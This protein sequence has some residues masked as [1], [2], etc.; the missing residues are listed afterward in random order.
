MNSRLSETLPILPQGR[1]PGGMSVMGF[2]VFAVLAEPSSRA[3]ANA[4][5]SM[6]T[7]AAPTAAVP[8]TPF[9]RKHR[10]SILSD[11]AACLSILTL[12]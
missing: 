6:L 8:R 3:A 11:M 7:C 9:A 1:L 12:R 2:S 10:R 4:F 5:S